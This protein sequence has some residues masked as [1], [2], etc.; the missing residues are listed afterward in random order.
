MLYSNSPTDSQTRLPDNV[1]LTDRIKLS[2]ILLLTDW[3]PTTDWQTDSVYKVVAAAA[4]PKDCLQ[5]LPSTNR[6]SET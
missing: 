1:W 6:Q 3:L 4:L 2:N 5:T